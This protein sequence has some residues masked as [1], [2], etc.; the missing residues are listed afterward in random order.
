MINSKIHEF[1]HANDVINSTELKKHIINIDSRFRNSSLES[2]AD[3]QYKFAHPYKNVIRMRVASVEIPQLWYTFSVGRGNTSFVIKAYDASDSIINIPISIASANYSATELIAALQDAFISAAAA[4]GVFFDVSMNPVTRRVTIEC[5]GCGPV[6]SGT[7]TIEPSPFT[8]DFAVVDRPDLN[9]RL[10]DWGLGYNLGFRERVVAADYLDASSSRVA[11]TGPCPLDV[12]GDLYALLGINEYYTVEHRTKDDYI[13][14][15]AKVICP[16]RTAHQSAIFD[17]GYTVL[18]NDYV[19]PSPSDLKQIHVKLMDA[20]GAAVELPCSN[21]SF[22]LE[23]TEVMDLKLYEVY[24]NNLW[25]GNV[26]RI[27]AGAG[28]SAV[29]GYVP[30]PKGY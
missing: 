7:P 14:A 26:P 4:F 21:F 15:L 16:P 24:R 17:S 13:Q 22:S 8:L 29:A 5:L 23:L 6:G 25:S 10:A 28:G 19:L 2:S 18:S 11:V 3:F 1:Y 27:S 12:T 9:G 30:L 20:Y